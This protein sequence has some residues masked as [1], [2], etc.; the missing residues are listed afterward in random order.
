MQRVGRSPGRSD[1]VDLRLL[2]AL[3][4]AGTV[5]GRTGEA[6][7]RVHGHQRLHAVGMGGGDQHAQL[8]GVTMADQG[9]TVR[10]DRIHHR[11]DVV[12]PFLQRRQVL[13]GVRQPDPA[14]VE[15]D[16]APVAGK[17]AQE[18]LGLGVLPH[19][20]DVTR[21]VERHHDIDGAIPNDLVGD[22]EVPAVCVVDARDHQGSLTAGQP[23][24]PLRCCGDGDRRRGIVKACRAVTTTD[25]AV[26]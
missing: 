23:R 14:H 17:P 19:Q 9:R 2:R 6:R 12:H 10:T 25:H 7:E 5:A 16:Q 15:E 18:P 13:D 20:L 4:H 24:K 26:S 22:L 8:P 3:G 21:P 1:R 11:A